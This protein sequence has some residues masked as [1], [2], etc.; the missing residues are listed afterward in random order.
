MPL[1]EHIEELRGRLLKCLLAAALALVVAWFFRDGIMQVLTRP[2]ALVM[3]AFQLDP[4][5]K[6]HTYLE[7]VAAQLKACLVAALLATSP[8]LLYQMW[9][10]AAPGLFQKERRFVVRLG[11][12]SLACLVAGV[13]FGY[14]LFIPLA[15]RFLIALSGPGTEPVL[16][17]GS[18]L[19]L[20]FVLT[21]ALGMVF[22]TPVIMFYLVRWGIVSVQDVQKHRKLAILAG[23]VL[24][25]FLT[26]PDP[27]TQVI[28][29]VP[30]IVL[31]DVGALVAAPGRDTFTSFARFT[32]TVVVI[33]LLA[34]AFFFLWPVARITATK[35]AVSVAG[36]VVP[37][38]ET[39]PVRR[40][41]ICSVEEGGSARMQFGSRRSAPSLLMASGARIQAHGTR[42]VS[43]HAGSVLVRKPSGGSPVEIRAV[44]ARATVREGTVELVV[45][46]PNTLVAN[47]LD[48]ELLARV[49][50]R[51][52]RIPAGRTSTFRRGG[53][54]L[55]IDDIE[56]RWGP[57]IRSSD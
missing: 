1:G 20:L 15:L 18:Y 7:P 36:R 24:A 35:G 33:V 52:V 42:S 48:G 19:S 6:F 4:S 2:H 16:M 12:V 41:Q 31:Y 27:F 50:G 54:P 8:F 43:I 51:T 25:A 26:P 29:A 53:E 3:H 30:L 21:V 14:F 22:Q 11:I 38:G 32:G 9:A 13:A 10:F 49:E 46:E 40:G 56:E 23:F 37:A 5:L 17:I 44:P 28:M 34:G 47:V 57:V 55:Q 39:A 45:P